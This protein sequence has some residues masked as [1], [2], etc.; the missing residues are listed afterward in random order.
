MTF[1]A[2]ILHGSLLLID[3][4]L[5]TDLVDLATIQWPLREQ[6]PLIIDISIL[7]HRGQ[8][9]GTDLILQRLYLPLLDHVAVARRKFTGQNQG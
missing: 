5:W 3:S 6:R 9:E 1:Y 4:D 7:H 8:T 2:G